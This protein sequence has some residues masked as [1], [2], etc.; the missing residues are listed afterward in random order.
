MAACPKHLSGSQLRVA[1][2]K[3]L[4]PIVPRVD[5]KSELF[6]ERPDICLFVTGSFRPVRR[7]FEENKDVLIGLK[8]APCSLEKTIF[9]AFDIHLNE[10][11]ILD[12]LTLSKSVEREHWY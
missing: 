7:V 6:Q 4:M 10:V 5:F 2:R 1:L 8:K 11:C 9:S 3:L 12:C